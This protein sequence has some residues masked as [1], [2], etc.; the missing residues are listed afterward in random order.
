MSGDRTAQGVERMS[1]EN[2][3]TW[4]YLPF[5]ETRTV[6]GVDEPSGSQD[7]QK[8]HRSPAHLGT[9][10]PA[11]PPARTQLLPFIVQHSSFGVS[12]LEDVFN[13]LLE[14]LHHHLKVQ[15]MIL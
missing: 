2:D 1:L 4:C 9:P 3:W 13:A 11:F 15:P 14:R 6:A 8:Y 12:L 5:D 10:R 7:V